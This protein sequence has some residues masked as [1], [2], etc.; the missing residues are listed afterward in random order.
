MRP[1]PRLLTTRDDPCRLGDASFPAPFSRAYL[2]ASRLRHF[3][4]PPVTIRVP[5]GLNDALST[6]PVWPFS[7]RIGRPVRASHTYRRAI[8]TAA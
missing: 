5:S 1:I 3:I 4:A 2:Q 7:S 8:V 6:A